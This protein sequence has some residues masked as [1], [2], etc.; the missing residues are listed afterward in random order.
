MAPD[1][2]TLSSPAI[3]SAGSLQASSPKDGP[4]EFKGIS[5]SDWG[6]ALSAS[7]SIHLDGEG[8]M[9]FEN[10]R[11]S[12]A[13]VA[14]SHFF[15][16]NS[17]VAHLQVRNVTAERGSGAIY[18]GGQVHID[19]NGTVLFENCTCKR[20]GAA[21]ASIGQL[22]LT[23][24]AVFVF[25][26][27]NST[28]AGVAGGGALSSFADVVLQLG[29]N[30]SAV[31]RQ[32]WAEGSGGAIYSGSDM[33]VTGG[34]ISFEGCRAGSGNGHAVAAGNG[35]LQISELTMVALEGMESYV[36]SPIFARSAAIPVGGDL[37]PEDVF[38]LE[39]LMAT[40]PASQ[41]DDTCPAGSR[42][43]LDRTGA[44]IPGKCWMCGSGT[45]SLA[46]SIVQVEGQVAN[47]EDGMR[48]VLVGR[49]SPNAIQPFRSDNRSNGESSKQCKGP[50]CCLGLARGEWEPGWDIFPV[51]LGQQNESAFTFDRGIFRTAEGWML[52]V[53]Y[54]SYV[55]NTPVAFIK[56]LDGL[57]W[58]KSSETGMFQVDERGHISPTQAP[59]LVFG[60]DHEVS[61]AF[62]PKNPYLACLPCHDVASEMAD[63]TQCRGGTSASSLRGYM[64]LHVAGKQRLDVHYCPNRVACPGSNLS[65]T[66]TGELA[67]RSRLC[68]KGY[69]SSPGCVRCASG[70]G[71]PF[72]DP[73]TC[74]PCGGWSL[75][76]QVGMAV[77][78]SGL[79]YA[80]AL[81]SARP[82]TDTQQIFKVFL[83]FLT[84]S[85]RSLSALPNTR[86]YKRLK[87]DIY[88]SAQA[89]YRCL[90]AVDLVISTEPG[91]MNSAYDCWGLV[92]GPVNLY[93]N[94]FLSWSI[95]TALLLLSWCWLGKRGWLK[96][97]VVWGNVFV[98][99]LVGAAAKLL[100]CFST[101]AGG[102]RILMY[103]AAFGTPCVANFSLLLKLPR[104]WLAAGTSLLLLLLGPLLWLALAARDLG[105]ELWDERRETVAFLVAG[106]RP[107][108]RWWE[109]MVLGR[110]AAIF[111]VATLLPMSWAPGAHLVYLLGIMIVAELLHITIRPYASTLLN[112]LEA[113]MLGI[114]SAC[115]VLVI[116]LLV[117]WPF[118]PY[119]IY[120]ASSALFFALTIGVYMYF[121]W[122]YI[123]SAFAKTPDMGEEDKA[124]EQG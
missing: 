72:L 22:K 115:L 83:A 98:P 112:R 56:G 45:V 42:F 32:C 53:P 9:V 1:V 75:L 59:D 123:R 26:K 46:T 119:A 96:A 73:F 25:A 118:M 95:P 27:C 4:L 48:I 2:E 70:Y 94:I 28:T 87:D 68:A 114:S 29:T 14:H 36:G 69:Q 58:S 117:E 113:Q 10:L 64:L 82:R 99:P 61:Y 101:Q 100:P 78:S 54:N 84:I 90:F 21:I 85:C 23:G 15:D 62:R 57:P 103:E 17:T 20:R 89:L 13:S 66:S 105:K 18:G 102:P 35:L 86:H 52:A 110:K 116:S 44:P 31:F 49:G 92:D 91:S 77:L 71:R 88:A 3:R 51:T 104:F 39:E 11:S 79:F 106:Y 120:V 63:K 41:G 38:Q 55:P 19:S 40:K 50:G 111:V 65:L 33:N 12:G 5:S 30:G 6:A 16:V 121:L 108:F 43:T 34:S 107:T 124:E 93:W 74:H 67:S 81:S 97:L 7:G 37:L 8:T 24:D 60:I 122:L 76:Q 109:V 47:S 80:L